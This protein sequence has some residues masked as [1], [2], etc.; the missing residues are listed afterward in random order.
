MTQRAPNTTRS[1]GSFGGLQLLAVWNKA[2]TIPG[3]DSMQ[4]RKDPCGAVIH[5]NKYGDTTL[6]G[7]EVDHIKP[8][9]AGGTDDLS[10]LQPL[11]W[12]NNR[13]KGDG[14]SYGW[15]CAVRG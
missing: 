7:W 11:Q 14:P 2:T 13:R 3:T 12:Q 9:S 6:H 10:N 1:G 4:V 15:I 5:W 8:V